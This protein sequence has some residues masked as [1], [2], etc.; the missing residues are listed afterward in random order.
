[1]P[2]APKKDSA[3]QV[4]SVTAKQAIIVALITSLAGLAGAYIANQRKPVDSVERRIKIDSIDAL[5]AGAVRVVIEVNGQAY[6][7]PSRAVWEAVGQHISQETFPLPP[8]LST[9][10]VHVS[11]YFLSAAGG[12]T[13]LFQTQEVKSIVATTLP[14]QTEFILHTVDSYLPVL[15]S[16]VSPSLR[17]G[18]SLY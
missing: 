10:S 17:I 18:L 3:V 13:T 1:M 15:R 8:G 7:Y 6:S 9:F 4:A 5:A 16:D 2:Q 12:E 14:T 11:A